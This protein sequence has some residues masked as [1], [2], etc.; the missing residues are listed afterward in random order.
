MGCE[1]GN[2][3]ISSDRIPENV[4]Y[5]SSVKP[6]SVFRNSPEYLAFSDS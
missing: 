5:H 3:I 4:S 1:M 6:R 2:S